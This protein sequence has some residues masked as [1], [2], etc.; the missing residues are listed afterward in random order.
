[1]KKP[2]VRILFT[3]LGK[4]I[5]DV[6]SDVLAESI[7]I[8]R[9]ETAAWRA[10][11]SDRTMAARAA[12][13]RIKGGDPFLRAEHG[14]SFR[15]N[16]VEE[17][18]CVLK[19]GDRVSIGD[20]EIAVKPV[21]VRHLY[22][23]WHRLEEIGGG[24]KGT[25]VELSSDT[26]RV[27]CAD[28]A[29]L[30]LR[31]DTVSHRHATLTVKGDECWV[32]DEASRNGT[33]VNG[34]RLGG[35]DRLLRDGDILAFGPF[36]YRF[37]DRAVPHVRT[38]STKGILAVL[39]VALIMGGGWY[40][41]Y[42]RTPDV[43]NYILASLNLAA[44]E[45]FEE[46]D[47]ELR[48]AR[49]ARGAEAAEAVLRV[50]KERLASW[51]ATFDA[52]TN[53]KQTLQEGRFNDACTQFGT[54][55]LNRRGAW[56][57]ANPTLEA[58]LAEVHEAVALTQLARDLWCA[59]F[60]TDLPD[61]VLRKLVAERVR[62]GVDSAGFASDERPWMKE[63][64]DC[65]LS[66]AKQLDENEARYALLTNDLARLSVREIELAVVTNDIAKALQETSGHVRLFAHMLGNPLMKLA[67]DYQAICSD[68][69]AISAL[70]AAAYAGNPLVTTPDDCAI[71]ASLGESQRWCVEA[72]R[73][74]DLVSLE[75]R[76]MRGRLRA[77]GADGTNA[78][79]AL[80]A[81]E[82]TNRVERAFR[83]ELLKAPRPPRP[84]RAE[85]IDD[86]YDRL[87][88]YEFLH[89]YMK[90]G[91][92]A[93][94]N[95][96]DMETVLNL[97]F[98]PAIRQVFELDAEISADLKTF[99]GQEFNALLTGRLGEL[100]NRLQ[101]WQNRIRAVVKRFDAIADA[102]GSGNDRRAIIARGVA[103]YLTPNSQ[104][105]KDDW[106]DFRK[107]FTWHQENVHARLN[108][109]DPTR[110]T[111]TRVVIDWIM[112]H[113]MPGSSSVKKAWNYR[114]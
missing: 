58:R 105:E 21:S 41:F 11:E 113:G 69:E 77:L 87:F 53:F 102:N 86:E 101:S 75:L 9:D 45:R 14:A 92:Y 5:A 73:R 68:A 8:G 99:G 60:D 50:R 79:A 55:S 33:R 62:L 63:L 37:L 57:W 22:A 110:P 100:K 39:A 76:A 12:V 66:N 67:V 84:N 61:A 15:V 7:L 31:D 95:D 81:L 97:N 108:Q 83:C 16:G 93:F 13:L 109:L 74:L 38:N 64:K 6:R 28:D 26:F 71:S 111:Q 40:V 23:S 72:R 34:Q 112:E 52:W 103:I 54:L 94:P 18:D 98:K 43:T 46:A 78:P 10:P 32:R 3:Y 36:E 42:Q 90:E 96:I 48:E 25:F 82:D 85:P 70:N 4:S 27:G 30:R 91:Y 80:V 88:G 24:L 49:T 104:V 29:D 106:D 51:R 56:D 2:P 89:T 20:C 114:R 107:R 44:D 59:R 65:V 1:M 35:K 47:T 17:H 19:V